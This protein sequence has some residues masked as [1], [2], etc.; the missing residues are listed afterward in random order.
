MLMLEDTRRVGRAKMKF[1]R[2]FD[3]DDICL[4]GVV[5]TLCYCAVFGVD[6]EIVKQLIPLA[7]MGFGWYFRSK[8]E[9]MNK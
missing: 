3:T 9:Q 5:G 4:I 1:I 6:N 7:S 8:V 2:D